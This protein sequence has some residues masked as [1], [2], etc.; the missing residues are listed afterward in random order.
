MVKR[1]VA[2]NCVDKVAVDGGLC[3]VRVSL[4][5]KFRFRDFLFSFFGGVDCGC[6]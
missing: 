2:V 5:A 3:G 4:G 6:E 1:V